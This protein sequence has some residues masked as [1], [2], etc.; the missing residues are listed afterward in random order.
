MLHHKK[1]PKLHG[2]FLCL[3]FIGS[4]NFSSQV[5]FSA[6]P[7]FYLLLPKTLWPVEHFAAPVRQRFSSLLADFAEQYCHWQTYCP[8]PS[9]PEYNLFWPVPECCL[10]LAESVFHLYF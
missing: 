4:L 6:Q 2:A 9:A 7:A 3:S 1:S 5:L 8:L 10:D